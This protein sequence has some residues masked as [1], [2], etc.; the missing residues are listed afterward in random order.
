MSDIND[1][2][3]DD[4]PDVIEIANSKRKT[5]YSSLRTTPL[6]ALRSLMRY[7]LDASY[8][9]KRARRTRDASMMMRKQR[10]K[11]RALDGW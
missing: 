11:R 7:L 2:Y 3:P 6:S 8:G 5:S 4:D 10:N 1:K 9:H